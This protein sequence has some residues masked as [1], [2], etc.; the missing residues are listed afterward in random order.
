MKSKC[1]YIIKK[2]NKGKF[3]NNLSQLPAKIKNHLKNCVH[4]QAYFDDLIDTEQ[5]VAEISTPDISSKHQHRL[6]NKIRS[7]IYSEDHSKQNSWFTQSAI[8]SGAATIVVV[9]LI[10]HYLPLSQNDTAFNQFPGNMDPGIIED[11]I[12]NQSNLIN[13]D[14]DSIASALMSQIDEEQFSTAID[15]FQASDYEWLYSNQN[16]D[17]MDNFS[18]TDW[19]ELRRFIS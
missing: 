17:S 7:R 4:C 3:G 2:L 12:I 9:M 18:E 19:E 1:Q 15:S 5:L 16:F 10:M 14:E 11:I 6:Q 8:L 13:L